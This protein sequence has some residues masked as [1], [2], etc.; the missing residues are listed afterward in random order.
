MGPESVPNNIAGGADAV[1]PGSIW[2]HHC[3][4]QQLPPALRDILKD[5]THI[6]Q[7]CSRVSPHFRYSRNCEKNRCFV[8]FPLQRLQQNLCLLVITLKLIGAPDYFP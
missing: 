5:G 6:L 1:G 7:M 4:R 2:E 8:E 3:A